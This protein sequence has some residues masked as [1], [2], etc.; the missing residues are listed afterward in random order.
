[1]QIRENKRI[2]NL[3]YQ[4]SFFEDGDKARWRAQWTYVEGKK[5]TKS[6]ACAKWVRKMHMNKLV[7]GGM[8]KIKRS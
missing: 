2:T 5:R 1:M 8:R 7:N 3:V 4:G 6:F